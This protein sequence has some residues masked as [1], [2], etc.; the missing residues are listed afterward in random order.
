MYSK[1]EEN[2]TMPVDW[3]DLNRVIELG[4]ERYGS[5]AALAEAVEATRDAIRKWRVG[6]RVPTSEMYQRL[7][8]AAGYTGKIREPKS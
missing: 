2:P 4:I 3:P 7:V 8:D 1:I 5:V 6:D